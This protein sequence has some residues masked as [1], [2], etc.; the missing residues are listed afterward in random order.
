F[1]NG[2]Q[3]ALER[4]LVSPKFL[5]RIEAPPAL[6]TDGN[7]RISDVELASRLSFFL[8]SSIPDDQLLNIAANGRLKDPVVFEQQVKRMLV[9][10]KAKALT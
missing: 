6:P 8:W 2:I 9:D 1:E 4:M 7:Y 3:S 5:Y 10:P